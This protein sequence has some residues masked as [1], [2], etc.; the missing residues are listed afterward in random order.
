MKGVR[1][2]ITGVRSWR[3][4]ENLVWIKFAIATGG[5]RSAQEERL[6]LGLGEEEEEDDDYRRSVWWKG[7]AEQTVRVYSM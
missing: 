4:T 2:G 1:L 6:I 7:S 3:R 5:G